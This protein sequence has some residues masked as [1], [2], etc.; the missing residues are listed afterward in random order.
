MDISF[1]TSNPIRSILFLHSGALGDTVLHLRV[2]Q[3]LRPAMGEGAIAWLG[4]DSWLPIVRRCAVVDRLAG[5]ET[6]R[7]HRLFEAGGEVPA[8]LA[9]WLGSFDII[10]NSLAP[11][12]SAAEGKLRQLARQA[13]ITYET[14]PQRDSSRHITRQWIDQIAAGL[15]TVS[16][17]LAA[18][19]E[20]AAEIMN[21][22]PHVL[23]QSAPADEAAARK[24]LQ[25]ARGNLPE[26]PLIFVHPGSGGRRKCWPIDRYVQLVEI[27]SRQDAMPV[28]ILGPAEVEQMGQSIDGLR[29]QYRLIADP[30]LDALMGLL[31][32]AAAYVGND[33]G[34]THLAAAMGVSAVAIFGPTDPQVW[35]SV[36]PKV[37]VL[38]SQECDAQWSD[39]PPDLVATRVL[40]HSSHDL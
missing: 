35:R 36:G 19:A 28:L 3:V 9:E 4:R 30:S 34:V 7:T 31:S 39:L 14:A 13:C 18:T 22:E 40:A 6:M 32:L 37:T 12:G 26:A 5:L 27:L 17:T 11:A 21:A 15:S 16:P 1:R 2:A 10:L 38:Q 23:L 33:S 29:R 20:R 24:L 8:D 25:A